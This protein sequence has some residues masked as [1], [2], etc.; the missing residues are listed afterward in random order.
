M[1]RH[2]IGVAYSGKSKEDIKQEHL[3]N[4]KFLMKVVKLNNAHY[5]LN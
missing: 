4:E 2:R 5:I 3:D 1:I